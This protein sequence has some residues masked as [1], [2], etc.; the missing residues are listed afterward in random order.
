MKLCTVMHW[1]LLGGLLKSVT[2]ETVHCDA[3]AL[4]GWAVKVCHR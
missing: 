1:P 3:L 4:A 2:D